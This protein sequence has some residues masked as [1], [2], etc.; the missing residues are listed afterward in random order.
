M[1]DTGSCDAMSLHMVAL[2]AANCVTMSLEVCFVDAEAP[3]LNGSFWR[4]RAG[5]NLGRLLE[6]HTRVHKHALTPR[7]ARIC[8]KRSCDHLLSM[9]LRI[10]D[11]AVVVP[12]MLPTTWVFALRLYPRNTASRN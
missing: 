3:W 1:L 6:P 7:V 12:W 11:L 5:L 2:S 9:G 10:N 4:W 8:A